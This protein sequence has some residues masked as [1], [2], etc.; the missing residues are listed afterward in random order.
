MQVVAMLGVVDDQQAAVPAEV[1][2]VDALL[3]PVQLGGRLA[4]PPDPHREPG[5]VRE[6]DREPALAGQRQPGAPRRLG[7]G[8][9]RNGVAAVERLE[10][11]DADLVA[12]GV[13]EPQ[14][15]AAVGRD[16]AHGHA[17][18]MVGDPPVAAAGSV[19]GVD[20]PRA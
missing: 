3:V 17:G 16:P 1:G 9:Q 11:P 7:V 6:P 18:G 2:D 12:L 8:H 19:P 4:D 20:L 14:H 13:V 5:P 15:A 10:P